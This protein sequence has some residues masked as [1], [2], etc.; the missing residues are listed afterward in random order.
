[1]GRRGPPRTPTE[2]LKLVGSWRADQREGKEPKPE[3]AKPESQVSLTDEEKVVYDQICDLVTG[4]GL[5]AKTDGNAIARYAKN[6]VL[7]NSLCE[8]CATNGEHLPTYEIIEGEQTIVGM[9][10]FPQSKQKNEVELMLI[11]L[12]RE[13]GLTPAARASLHVETTSKPQRMRRAR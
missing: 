11:R 1:M 12:E 10:R 8:F 4:M 3:A 7:Y 9:E 5:Q 13:F 6:L 2:H